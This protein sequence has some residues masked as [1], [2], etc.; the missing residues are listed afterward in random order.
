MGLVCLI[1]LLCCSVLSSPVL[2]LRAASLLLLFFCRRRPCPPSTLHT[3]SSSPW[4]S[5]P[6]VLSSQVSC[7]LIGWVGILS[8]LSIVSRLSAY[9]STQ[10]HSHTHWRGCPPGGRLL[11]LGVGTVGERCRKVKQALTVG[12]LDGYTLHQIWS[13]NIYKVY[14][15]I[16]IYRT[17]HR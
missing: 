15:Y 13:A 3:T 1:G 2:L 14:K 10:P 12:N 8:I 5:A 9:A 7:G 4:L 6:H 16:Y 17:V 11:E